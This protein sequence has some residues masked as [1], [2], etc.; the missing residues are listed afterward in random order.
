MIGIFVVCFYILFVSWFAGP[1]SPN[2]KEKDVCR[3]AYWSCQSLPDLVDGG[4]PR[5]L[6]WWQCEPVVVVV[7]LCVIFRHQTCARLFS[8]RYPTILTWWLTILSHSAS[9]SGRHQRSE[10]TQLFIFFLSKK[11]PEKKTWRESAGDGI[12]L[13]RQMLTIGFVLDL[14]IKLVIKWWSQKSQHLLLHRLIEW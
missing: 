5:R 7:N 9:F 2:K 13:A 4:C 3:A 12:L 8:G 11:D 6:F 10:L 14:I 1:P